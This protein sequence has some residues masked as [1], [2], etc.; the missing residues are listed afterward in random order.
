MW[1]TPFILYCLWVY[2]HCVLIIRQEL[3]DAL[4]A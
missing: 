1:C 4:C 2:M 3:I